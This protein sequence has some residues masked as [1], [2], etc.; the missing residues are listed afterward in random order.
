MRFSHEIN[1]DKPMTP[2]Q[3]MVYIDE[4]CSLVACMGIP[5]VVYTVVDIY[6]T[7]KVGHIR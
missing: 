2:V 6:H 1:E 5:S 4:E 3:F 7:L